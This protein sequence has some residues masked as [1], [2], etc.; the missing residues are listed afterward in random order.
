M[1][2]KRVAVVGAGPAGL[3]T[4]FR[5]DRAGHEV[6][7][8]ES[9]DRAGGKIHTQRVGD[10]VLDAGATAVPSSYTTC[11]GSRTTPGWPG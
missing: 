5:L 8:L 10:Y 11:S 4:A 1:Q 6:V 9:R 7:V 2:R 3:A